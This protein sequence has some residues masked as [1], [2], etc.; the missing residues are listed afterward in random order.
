LLEDV[1]PLPA[2]Q[3]NLEEILREATTSRTKCLIIRNV[4]RN[5]LSNLFMVAL[6][7]WKMLGEAVEPS[8]LR[9]VFERFRAN[10]ESKEAPAIE[11]TYL[12]RALYLA[13]GWWTAD[14]PREKRRLRRELSDHLSDSAIRD[15]SV[16]PFDARR[17]RFL[18]ELVA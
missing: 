15:H 11:V 7:R 17:Y 6:L 5:L 1:P 14:E 4:E 10:L 2:V 16:F 12:V 3:R 9:L 18:R 8:K 13:S